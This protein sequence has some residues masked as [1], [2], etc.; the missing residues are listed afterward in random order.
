MANLCAYAC[1]WAFS[2][3][4]YIPLKEKCYSTVKWQN[5][6]K[7]SLKEDGTI[8]GEEK[9]ITFGEEYGNIFGGRIGG[10][11]CIKRCIHKINFYNKHSFSLQQEIYFITD[12]SGFT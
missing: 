6:K 3:L 12:S 7:N 4:K 8:L 10:N 5:M 2:K 1:N 9:V 11:I